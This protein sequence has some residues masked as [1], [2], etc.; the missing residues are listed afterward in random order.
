LDFPLVVSSLPI[1]TLLAIP[2]AL[3]VYLIDTGLIA[4]AMGL[5]MRMNI[6]HL[7]R[8]RFQWLGVNYLT[9]GILGLFLAIGYAQ[10]G[11][12]SVVL[13]ILPILVMYA[14][15]KMYVQRTQT[16]VRE[17]RRMNQELAQANTEISK[18]NDQIQRLNDQ[19]FLILAKVIDTRDPDVS[20]HA[21]RVAEY[22]MA[23]ATE[24][25]LPAEQQEYIRQAALLHDIGKLGIPESILHKAEKLSPEEYQIVKRHAQMGAEL[26]E[27]SDGLRYLAPA[28][29]HHHERWDGKGYPNGLRREEIPLAA[30]I[31]ALCDAV[32]VMASGRHYESAK[33]FDAILSEL[34][35]NMG[36]Q[37]DPLVVDTFIRATYAR[38][39]LEENT[40][41]TRFLA[42][43]E[44]VAAFSTPVFFGRVARSA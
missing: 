16:S 25:D 11:P 6:F 8:E 32:E 24:L 36:T 34:R 38:K 26:L 2:A 19:L 20:G 28:I 23:V 17:L 21:T 18:A 4:I 43:K 40:S 35:R 42:E 30:R 27:A 12:W 33:P 15:Q 41:A 3:L 29:R 1:L 39:K 31:L 22:A 5:A 13:F 10:L 7:W 44:K 14:T 9:L 37:F